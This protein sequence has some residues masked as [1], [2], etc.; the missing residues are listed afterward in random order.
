MKRRSAREGGAGDGRRAGARRQPEQRRV[1]CC[2][3]A[4]SESRS[5]TRAA[6]RTRRRRRRAAG[7]RRPRPRRRRPAPPRAGTDW[8]RALRRSSTAPSAARARAAP[9]SRA[10][11]RGERVVAGLDRERKA[12][13]G[14]RV[15]VRAVDPRRRGQCRE[16]R[17]R[18]HHL[19]RRA[20]RTAGRSR[21]RTACRRRTRPGASA[22]A[23]RR[24]RCA[25]PCGPARRAPRARARVPGT[26]ATSP[27]A[28]ARVRPGIR[29]RA[30]PNTG[31][32][33]AREQLG[34]A[35]D[36]VAVVMRDEDRRERQPLAV[37]VRQHRRRV[38]RIDDDRVQTRRA[39]A[40]CSCR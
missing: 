4:V 6:R 5:S 32:A 20:L 30:G 17:E 24:R 39:T 19:R 26:R 37:E 13:V 12:Q 9:A 25:P 31:T 10:C 33:R 14:Q 21:R 38:A 3:A 35:A 18:R 40:R 8:S 27:P 36:V 15:L 16:P 7:P 22:S 29:S 2:A 11:L 23:R 28:S 1:R 34:D